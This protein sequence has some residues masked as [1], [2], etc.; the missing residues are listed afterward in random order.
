[1]LVGEN[2]NKGYNL[3]GEKHQQGLCSIACWWK[4][5]QGLKNESDDD[6]IAPAVASYLVAR[7]TGKPLRKVR[8]MR[9]KK[10]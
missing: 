4:H 8:W 3:V 7:K 6:K 1:L 2:T 9:F 5:Q 10:N